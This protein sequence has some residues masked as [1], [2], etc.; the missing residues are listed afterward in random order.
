VST[1]AN[2]GG[3]EAAAQALL[4]EGNGVQGHGGVVGMRG[5]SLRRHLGI[6]QRR[7]LAER[8]IPSPFYLTGLAERGSTDLFTPSTAEG[9]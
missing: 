7:L 5:R 8:V 9:L 6:N 1:A 2:P 3:G 4:Q